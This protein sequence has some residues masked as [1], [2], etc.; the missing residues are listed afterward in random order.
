MT[1]ESEHQ[2]VLAEEKLADAT[3]MVRDGYSK[4][5][6]KESYLAALAA[7]RAIL[8]EVAGTPPKTHRGARSEYNRLCHER[9]DLR[10]PPALFL[11]QGFDAK[12]IFDYGESG[13]PQ[14]EPAEAIAM[15]TEYLA[16]ARRIVLGR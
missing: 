16:A 1:A 6:L 10:L 11:R 5:G 13:R 9:P 4:A 2:L 14:I 15:A 7:V 3:A 8:S 12:Q